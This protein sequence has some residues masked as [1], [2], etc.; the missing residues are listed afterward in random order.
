MISEKG[1]EKVTFFQEIM[2]GST[3]YLD[4][5]SEIGHGKLQDMGNYYRILGV[6]HGLCG[7]S[8]IIFEILYFAKFDIR[9]G[10]T[11]CDL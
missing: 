1:V 6:I 3:Q 11:A 8:L 4:T 5:F 2:K 9:F 10:L 7:K